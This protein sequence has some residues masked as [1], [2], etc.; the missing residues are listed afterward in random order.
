[1]KLSQLQNNANKRKFINDIKSSIGKRK[2]TK[3]NTGIKTANDLAQ[4]IKDGDR[5]SF[6]YKI[7]VEEAAEL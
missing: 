7:L 5:I 2:T 3:T 1:M 6:G 4:K